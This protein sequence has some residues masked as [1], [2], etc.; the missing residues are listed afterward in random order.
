MMHPV[1]HH[2]D[3]RDV[4]Q[5]GLLL[6]VA[7]LLAGCSGGGQGRALPGAVW[8]DDARRTATLPGTKPTVIPSSTGGTPVARGAGALPPGVIPRAAWNSQGM[9]TGR[10]TANGQ[11]GRMGAITRI[12][13]HHDALDSSSIRSQSDAAYRLNAIRNGQMTRKPEPFADIG[14]H[15]IIDPQGRI[16]EGRSIAY[17]GA[18]VRGQNENNLGIMLMGH[19]DQQRPTSSAIESLDAFVA[20]QMARY[21]IPLSRVKTHQE[22]ASTECP[23]RNLQRYMAQSRA[24][25]GALARA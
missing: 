16:W 17:Q 25:G 6:G 7:A 3:R 21:G 9:V 11:N 23:G 22:L 1:N 14:Y 15:Y 5:G 8:P 13:I 2:P 19:F 20:S 12:T 10:L 24:R 4:L 18:H